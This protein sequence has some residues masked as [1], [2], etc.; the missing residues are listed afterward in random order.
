MQFFKNG[1]GVRLAVVAHFTTKG[2]E[3]M[4]DGDRSKNNLTVTTA[5]F[6]ENANLVTGLEKI[7]EGG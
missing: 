6:D 5:I 3:F 1:S 7:I 2:I 4:R